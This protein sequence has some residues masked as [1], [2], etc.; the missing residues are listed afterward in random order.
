VVWNA[1]TNRFNKSEGAGLRIGER[2]EYR[3]F[4]F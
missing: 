4:S 3:D 2:A 1:A